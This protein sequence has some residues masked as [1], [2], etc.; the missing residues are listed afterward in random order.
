[1]AV[2]ADE[3][4]I[5][6]DLPDGASLPPLGDLPGVTGTSRPGGEQ[7]DAEYYDT[8]GLRLLQAG[9][10]LRRREGGHDAGWHLKLPAGPG[11][12][13]EIRLP[14]GQAGG[15]VP[16]E[17]A[18][19]VPAYTRG[20]PLRPVARLATARG[21]LILHGPRGE[22]LAE[23]ADDD[24]SAQ[25]MGASTTVSRWREAEV[26]LT[27]GSR[28]LLAAVERELRR[29]GLHPAGHASK[30]ARALGWQRPDPRPAGRRLGPSSPA[31]DVV[32][33]YLREQAA[34]LASLDPLVR[35][36][37]PDAV[38]QMRVTTRRLRGTLR[39][40]RD[41]ISRDA[42]RELAA[43]LQW[44][45]HLLG[46]PRDG[47]VLAARFEAESRHIP[48]ELL[49]GPVQARVHEHFAP[50]RAAAHRELV[51][52]LGSVRY[53][54][55]LDGLDQLLDTPPLEPRASR[56][57]ADVLPAAV[58][59][60]YRQTAR[61]MERAHRAPP[62]QARDTGLHQARKAARR[63]RYAAE[64][65]APAAGGQARGFARQMKKMQSV[66]GEHQDAV[67]ARQ[68]ARDLAA[69]AHLAG[70]NA[71]SYGLLHERE[72]EH[73]RQRQEQA[74]RAWRKASRRR[75]RRWL[76]PSAR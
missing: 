16:A 44:L 35:R 64:A 39:S 4:E 59:R 38:H 41:V 25:T 52:A 32:L 22:S 29:A 67:I 18:G 49:I 75:Y 34:T 58:R 12:R 19:L 13:R 62:G 5:K 28:K 42:T 68:V 61:R 74:G 65:A 8:A 3:T 11:T 20:E 55:L 37:E 51:T 1:M 33:A 63:S 54:G 14:A 7:L 43:T 45:G 48:A 2:S 46:G 40:Y 27:G 50:A 17:L 26:E 69:A 31:G 36:D 70:E 56:P 60:T 66:L 57:A 71:F 24:V 21:R 10:T 15:P 73:G 9:V 76:R 53:F 23:V 30:L 6:Y 72:A 47:E